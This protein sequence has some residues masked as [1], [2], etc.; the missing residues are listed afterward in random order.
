MGQRLLLQARAFAEQA[1][2]FPDCAA[3]RPDPLASGERT[4]CRRGRSVVHSQYESRGP[5]LLTAASMT[6]LS[7]LTRRDQ[8]A[9]VVGSITV[10]IAAARSDPRRLRAALE[11]R[12]R[13]A[14][15]RPA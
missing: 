11:P 10:P 15:A 4:A 14:P 13:V 1:H 2:S 5:E 7:G 12:R 6:S 8:D 3:R 9:V